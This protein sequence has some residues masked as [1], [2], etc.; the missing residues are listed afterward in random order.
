VKVK[1]KV[2]ENPITAAKFTSFITPVSISACAQAA[3]SR[4][5]MN[6]THRH[7][8]THAC[9][10][11]RLPHYDLPRNTYQ[12]NNETLRKKMNSKYMQLIYVICLR[13][14]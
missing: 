3:E 7:H 5:A 11:M 13:N 8:F 2:I 14:A 1:F 6:T 10:M 9:V 12:V 4:C